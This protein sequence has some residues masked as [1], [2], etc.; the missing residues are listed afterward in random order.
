VAYSPWL[1]LRRGDVGARDL[2]RRRVQLDG[3]SVQQVRVLESAQARLTRDL[4]VTEATPPAV[5]RAVPRNTSSRPGISDTVPE[6][7]ADPMTVIPV[8]RRRGRPV[9]R[10]DPAITESGGAS[11]APTGAG[12][13]FGGASGRSEPVTAVPVVAGAT[14]RGAHPTDVHSGQRR[15]EQPQEAVAVPRRGR[16]GAEVEAR[17][18][19][20]PVRE[21][22]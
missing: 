12:S 7:R 18:P 16:S 11:I 22:E 5:A 9:D 15:A 3:A 20:R 21:R 8:V 19:D 1:Y 10:D 4:V 14:S 6:M 13:R 17:T 2:S